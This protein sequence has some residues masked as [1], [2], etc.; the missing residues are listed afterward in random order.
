M[1]TE[2]QKIKLIQETC[3]IGDNAIL[4]VENLKSSFINTGILQAQDHG[5]ID[6]L[7]KQAAKLKE[8][9]TCGQAGDNQ[10]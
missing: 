5:R 9:S 4:L 8:L 1:M 2:K 10:E 3:D 7:V 6:N